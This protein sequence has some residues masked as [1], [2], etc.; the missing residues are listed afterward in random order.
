[1]INSLKNK[2]ILL[3]KSIKHALTPE[4]Q[5][6]GKKSFSQCGEDLIIKFIFDQLGINKPSYLDIGAHHPFDIN[7][8]QIFYQNG[9]VGINVEPDPNLYKEFI[10][11]RKQ[12]INLN[13]GVGKFEDHLYLNVMN[14]ATLNTFSEVEANRLVNE[15]GFKIENRIKIEIVP[16]SLILKKYNNGIFPDFLTLDVEGLDEEII[17][18][19]DF[20][21]SKP[22][23]ICLETISYS[24]TG[25]GIKNHEM[26]S[27][28]ESKGYLK[29]ADTYINTIFVL[30]EKWQRN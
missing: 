3:L 15:F 8:T 17:K 20:E 11:N 24:E 25:H 10:I 26:T 4:T 23:V 22:I 5:I 9:S 6:F 30:R 21:K 7:N 14:A 27:Y 12:D 1:M 29:Y 16:I 19:I 13:C 2:I 28:L 18:S